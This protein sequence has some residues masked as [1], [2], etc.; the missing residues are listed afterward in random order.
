VVA[1]GPVLERGM[2]S[3]RNQVRQLMVGLMALPLTALPFD[4][5]PMPW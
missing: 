4:A 3:A 2:T 1:R 5:D